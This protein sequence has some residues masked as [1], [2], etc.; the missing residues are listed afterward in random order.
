MKRLGIMGGTFDPIHFGHLFIAE[1]ARLRCGL[2]K[3]LWIP[4]NVPAHR[5]GKVAAVDSE[6]RARLTQIGIR[7]NAA[8]ELS[9]IELER[10][11][12]SFL[13]DTLNE[14]QEMYVETELFFICGADS[15]RDVLTWY[16]GAELFDLC[17]FV[18]A[19]RPGIERVTA[20]ANLSPE[21]NARVVWLDVP[22]L[23]IASRDIRE[24]VQNRLPIRYLVPDA[25]EREIRLHSLYQPQ[26]TK[27]IE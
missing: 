12:R 1:E 6:T 21:Q 17:T 15:M 3:V 24:R 16:R 14:L 22:G 8:F 7:D 4:N 13:F 9:R 2:D 19:S 25:V 11:G 5:E 23:H 20:M 18:A 26:T 27:G 10:P